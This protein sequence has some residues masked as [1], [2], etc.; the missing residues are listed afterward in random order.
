MSMYFRYGYAGTY[1]SC[2]GKT[3]DKVACGVCPSMP[4]GMVYV[5]VTRVR[6]KEDV[7]FFANV[8]KYNPNMKDPR[9]IILDPTGTRVDSWA[10]KFTETLRH[11][12]AHADVDEL[13]V[14]ALREAKKPRRDAAVPHAV[15]CVL[16]GA[17]P[18]L[19]FWPCGHLASCKACWKEAQHEGV[20]SCYTCKALVTRVHKVV[21]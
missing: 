19:A 21:C 14:D 10:V 5:G 12:H 6:R 2:Q 11:A 8:N 20:M 13:A 1:I 9:K 4:A 17:P 15:G 16:C 18:E 3:L 7:C